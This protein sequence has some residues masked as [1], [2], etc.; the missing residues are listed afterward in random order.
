M[1]SPGHDDTDRHAVTDVTIER[2]RAVTVT[3]ADGVVCQFPLDRLRAACPCASCR[4]WRERGEPAWPRPGSSGSIS[5]V[6]AELT[7][8]WGLS[9][10]WSDGHESGIYAWAN[11]RR[12]WD[13]GLPTSF[14]VD[15]PTR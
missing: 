14:T 12:W 3:Y 10:V 11:L 6:D 4:G 13:D 5:I 8:A 7:G 1:D 2:E 9:P 15:L